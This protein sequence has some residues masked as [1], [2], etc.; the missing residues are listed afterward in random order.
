M[1][2]QIVHCHFCATTEKDR[3]SA[4][5]EGWTP[6]FWVS[7]NVPGDGPVCPACSSKYL[8]DR[9]NDPIMKRG[10]KMEVASR[11]NH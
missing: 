10:A 11:S 4:Q 7:R 6:Y 5:A 1:A 8:R 9:A 2:T 3:K